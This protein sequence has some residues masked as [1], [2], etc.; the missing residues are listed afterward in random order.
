MVSNYFVLEQVVYHATASGLGIATVNNFA[1]GKPLLGLLTAGL[2]LGVEVYAV[3]NGIKHGKE[4]FQTDP[5]RVE[6]T[7]RTI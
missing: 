4:L 3:Y 2:G 1:N 6:L 5:T 7:D